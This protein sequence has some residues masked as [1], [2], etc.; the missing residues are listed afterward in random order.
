M[1][2]VYLIVAG[3]AGIVGCSAGSSQ[4]A[5]SDVEAEAR[6]FMADYVTDFRAGDVEAVIARY[7]RDGAWRVGQGVAS[8]VPF[9]SIAAGYRQGGG[10]P[11]AFV[12][13][14]LAY[15]VLSDD[16]VLVVGTFRAQWQPGM[17]EA[18]TSY[19]GLLVR[20]DGQLRLR[21]ED[22]SSHNPR[23][24]TC[25]ADVEFCEEPLDPGAAARFIGEYD[26]GSHRIRVFRQDD[27][28]MIEPRPLPPMRILY[29]GNNE[30]R[31]AA[32]PAFI[33]RFDGNGPRAT[34]I[35][36]LQGAIVDVG[37]RVE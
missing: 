26:A 35:T 18:I 9:D 21:L 34:S 37:T 33:I 23:S 30:F 1:K 17:P 13:G 25:A 20:Q 29:D 4:S 36:V 24:V 19:T 7:H 16:A 27:Q 5:P 22:E 2:C 31:L 28:M 12:M 6:Q 10:P 15:E 8:F 3:T 14:D 11:A 32:S